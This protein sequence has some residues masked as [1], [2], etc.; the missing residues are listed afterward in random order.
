MNKFTTKIKYYWSDIFHPHLN[1]REIL[2]LTDIINKFVGTFDFEQLRQHVV[3]YI[4]ELFE[5]DRCFI[6]D[7]DVEKNKFI[8]PE[9]E[10]LASPELKSFKGLE[11]EKEAPEINDFLLQGNEIVFLN[12][13]EYIK[14]NNLQNTKSHEFLKNFNIKSAAY[15]PIKHD[16]KLIG[17]LGIVYEREKRFRYKELEL[18]KKFTKQISLAFFQMKINESLDTC[19][20]REITLRNSINKIRST[21]NIKKIKKYFVNKIGKYL[22]ADRVGLSLFDEEKKIF[23]PFENESEY[24]SN[25][26]QSSFAG[27]DWSLEEIQPF[28]EPLKEK[29]EVNFS[30]I[31]VYIKENHFENTRIE[32]LFRSA[33]IGSSYN[34]PILWHQ[35][36]FGYFCIDFNKKGIELAGIDLNFVRT[37]TDQ[38]A[39]GICHAKNYEKIQK[40]YIRNFPR[41]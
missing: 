23:L 3:D 31:D 2:M 13:E 6:D 28:I 25:P 37:L 14:E 27:Y 24:L 21:L 40:S 39:M 22:N 15:I 16:T 7:F 1:N 11:P 12:S 10:Y 30:D 5:A 8:T 38:L 17:M 33:G 26:E 29:K 20:K 9:Y 32:E 36:L 41:N 18:I 19:L 34:F 35:N 4:G